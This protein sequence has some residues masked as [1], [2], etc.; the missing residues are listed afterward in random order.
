MP[1]AVVAPTDACVCVCVCT[2]R[3]GMRLE[4]I[5]VELSFVFSQRRFTKTGL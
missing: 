4:L 5:F 2:T 1:A 3:F